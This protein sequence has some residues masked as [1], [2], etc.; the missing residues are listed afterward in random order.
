ML[1]PVLVLNWETA[2]V[3][4]P[5]ITALRGSLE[6]P[7]DLPQVCHLV[8]VVVEEVPEEP[9]LVALRVVALRAGV[10]SLLQ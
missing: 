1:A 3:A 4:Q 7:E 6:G 8:P 9:R 5:P 2:G 10:H